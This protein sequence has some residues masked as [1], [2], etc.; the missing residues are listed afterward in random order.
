MKHYY[1]TNHPQFDLNEE[2]CPIL[3]PNHTLKVQRIHTHVLE[4]GNFEQPGTYETP[5][6]EHPGATQYTWVNVE[7]FKMHKN[8][9]NS[10]LNAYFLSFS[11]TGTLCEK[12]LRNGSKCP[13]PTE[14][15]EY[16]KARGV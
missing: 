5:K 6:I 2:K 9:R 1:H 7:A 15:G 10:C 11:P 13:E 16:C 8:A 4:G 3:W 14:Q 12:G